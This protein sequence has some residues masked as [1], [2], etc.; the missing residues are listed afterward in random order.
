MDGGHC[1]HRAGTAAHRLAGLTK[2]FGD[3]VGRRRHRP[4][5]RGGR[6]LLPARP[7]RLRQ[8]DDAADDRR[9]RAADG[10]ADPARRPRPRRRPAAPPAGEHRLPVLRPVPPPDVE[11]NVAYG[12]RW[13]RTGRSTRPNGAGAS[14]EAIELVRLGGLED[15]RPAQLSGGQQQRVALARALI[16]RPKVLL[17]DEPLGALDARLRKDLQVDLA[18]LQREVGITFVYVTHDQEEALTMSH[19]LAVMDTGQRRPG[20]HARRGLRAAGDGV[21]RRLPRRRQ[22]ARRRRRGR[23]AAAGAR[24][25]L[26]EFALDAAGDGPAGPVKLVIRP[27]R[28]RVAPGEAAGPNCL[29][30]MVERVVYVGSTTQVHVRLPGGEAVQSLTA[31]DRRRPGLA[32][33]HARSASPC[34][35][36]PC[37]PC[38]PDGRASSTGGPPSTPAGRRA[39]APGRAATSGPKRRSGGRRRRRRR[40]AGRHHAR[41][42]RRRRGAAARRRRAAAEQRRPRPPAFLAY[43]PAAPATA[44]ALFDAIV[45]AWSFSGESWQ[46]AGAAVAAENAALDWLRSLAGLPDGRGRLL[47][48]AAARPATSAGSPSPATSGAGDTRRPGRLAIACAPSAHSSV[49]GA[50]ALLDL[51]VVEVPATS[52]IGS[53]APALAAPS[54]DDRCAPSSPAPGRPTPAPSTTSPASPTCARDARLWF[55]VDAAYGGAALCVPELAGRFAGI[56]RADSLVI[57]PHK[58]L[59]APLDCAA[60]LYRDPAPAARTH[61]QSAAYL[62]AFGDEHVNPSDLASTSPG[63]HAG[64]RS[65]SPSS[66]TAPTPSPPPCGPASTSPAQAADLVRAIGDPVRLVMEPELSV[67]LFERHGWARADWDRWA[68]DALADGLAFV[69]P[70]RWHGRDVGRLAFLHPHTDLAAV[71]ALL[72]RLR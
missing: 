60:L 5:H 61:R 39:G 30:G 8:D 33:R 51:D 59:F 11:D 47:R 40:R 22:P 10:R 26:G 50:A 56:E 63:G 71:A 43:I 18:A 54:T 12:L 37:A 41:R 1:R 23:P 2:S 9:L 48:V 70:T 57:D 36:T 34:P 64:C 6:V 28:V 15:R 53:P 29:P 4:G 14:V 31:N 67:V 24:Y 17:L 3:V 20:R 62:D 45:G 44:A 21:R 46:E 27:E 25:A 72:D 7:V 35:P 32:G 16:L 13:R 52:A 49:R 66:S 58:W 19:R 65:G 38:R 68:A 42:D 69:A 55:H